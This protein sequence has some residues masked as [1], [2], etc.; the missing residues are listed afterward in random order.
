MKLFKHKNIFV[1]NSPEERFGVFTGVFISRN[2]LIEECHFVTIGE[3]LENE[4]V[5]GYMYN[6]ESP[7]GVRK[8]IVPLG[9]GA[10]YNH[11][12]SPNLQMYID[13]DRDLM[14][15]VAIRNIFKDEQLYIDY[16]P[17]FSLLLRAKSLYG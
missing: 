13:Y 6:Y 9:Y 3:G 16:G 14:V 15:F 11:N 4:T 5:R 1:K 17:D 10:I 2:T 8:Q 12:D 7:S